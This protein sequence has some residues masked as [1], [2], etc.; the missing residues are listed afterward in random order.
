VLIGALMAARVHML[1]FWQRQRAI[2]IVAGAYNKGLERSE[3][4]T[5]R[6]SWLEI[7]WL[8]SALVTAWYV[9]PYAGRL[10]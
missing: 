4:V 1:N 5:D 7:S 2:P 10:E 3:N 6:L 8:A 9:R